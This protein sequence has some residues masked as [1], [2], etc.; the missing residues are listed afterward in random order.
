MISYGD[1]NSG[2]KDKKSLC[3]KKKKIIVQM[4]FLLEQEIG[5]S[6]SLAFKQ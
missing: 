3:L 1:E 6:Q 5:P 4:I 2:V